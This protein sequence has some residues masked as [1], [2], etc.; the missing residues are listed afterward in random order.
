[1][2]VRSN[3]LGEEETDWASSASGGTADGSRDEQLKRTGGRGGGEFRQKQETRLRG[4][5]LGQEVKID[6]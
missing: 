3:E 1:M 6:I 2:G 5:R 4:E